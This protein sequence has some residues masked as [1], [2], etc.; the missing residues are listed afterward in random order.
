MWR[1]NLRYKFDTLDER[2]FS[3]K[4]SKQLGNLF[5]FGAFFFLSSTAAMHC[6][7]KYQHVKEKKVDSRGKSMFCL[8]D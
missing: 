2:L 4:S 8:C 5:F 3:A 7:T 6:K 1:E